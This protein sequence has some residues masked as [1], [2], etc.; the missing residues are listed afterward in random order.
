M[1]AI[2]GGCLLAVPGFAAR[3]VCPA[4]DIASLQTCIQSAA[5]VSDTT[6]TDTVV[7]TVAPGLYSG[8]QVRINRRRD[9]WIVGDTTAVESTQPRILYQDT[10]RTYTGLDPALRA[11]TSAAGT[12]GQNNGTVWIHESD[13]IRLMGLLIDGNSTTSRINTASR[14]FAYGANLGQGAPVEIRGNVGVNILLSRNVQLRYLSVTNAWNGISVLSPNLGG[15]FAFPDP[16]DPVEEVVA[17]LPTSRAGRYGNHLVERCRIHDNVF[18]VLF[19]RDWDLNSVVRNNLFWGNYLRHWGDPRT[20]AGYIRN[21]EA[22]DKAKR[23]DGSARSL[24]YTTVGGAFLMTDVALTPYRIHNNTFHNNAT[25]FSGYY[26][27]GTQ[28]LFYNNLVGKPYQFFRRALDLP[29][30]ATDGSYTAFRNGYTQTERNSEMLQY[31]SEHQRANRVVAQDSLPANGAVVPD[32]WSA[33]GGNFRLYNMRQIRRGPTQYEGWNWRGNPRSWSNAVGE[34]DSLSMTWVPDT[35]ALGTIAQQADT[36]GVVRWV[37]HNMWTGARRD[38]MDPNIGQNWSPPWLPMDIRRSLGDPAIFRNTGG[39]DLRWTLRMPFDTVSST[40]S[41]SWLTPL[42]SNLR[43]TGW[44]GYEGTSTQALPIGAYDLAGIWA[45]PSRRI[46]LRDTLIETV[47]DS[48]VRFRM[49]VSGEGISDSDIVSL[50]VHEAKFYNDVPV[51]DTVFNQ[52]PDTPGSANTTTRVNSV[53]SSKPWPLPYA[54]LSDDYNRPGYRVD[55]SL[56]RRKLAPDNVFLARIGAGKRLPADSLYARAEVVLKATLKDGSVVY[57]NPGVF[58]FSRPRFQFEVTVVDAATGIELPLDADGLSRVAQAYQPLKVVVKARTVASLPVPFKGYGNVQMGNA[59]ALHG[60]DGDDLQEGSA[61]LW[62]T[63]S[64]NDTVFAFFDQNDS[65]F[66]TLRARRSPSSGTLV[67][68]AVFVGTNDRALPYFIEGRSVPV[69]VVSGAI[70][71]ATI[72]SVLRF[73]T[74][75]LAAPDVALKVHA[76]ANLAGRRDTL[77]SDGVTSSANVS[78]GPKGESLRLVLQVRDKYGN[79]VQDSSSA[80]KALYIRLS[81]VLAPGRYPDVAPDLTWL[82]L[83]SAGTATQSLRLEWDSTGRAVAWVRMSSLPYRSVLAAL[84]A[85]IVDS[86][87]N[88]IGQ[89]GASRDSGIADTTWIRSDRVDLSLAWADTLGGTFL[90]GRPGWVGEWIP[91]RLKLRDGGRGVS[92]TGNVALSSSSP[93]SF[94]AVRGDTTRATS[95]AFLGDSLSAIVWIRASDSV[96]ST[97][98]SASALDLT[99]T[100]RDLRFRYPVAVSSSF[101]DRDCDGRIDELTVRLDGPVLFRATSGTLLGDTLD[102]VFPHQHLSPSALAAPG[103]V[104]IVTDSVIVVS[105]DPAATTAADIRADRLFLRNPLHPDRRLE[106]SL[107]GLQDQAPPVA[108]SAHLRQTGAGVRTDSLV[109]RLSETLDRSAL[110]AGAPAPF[111]ARRGSIETSL[112][113]TRLVRPVQTLDSGLYAFVFTGANGLLSRGD[114]IAIDSASLVDLAG[115]RSGRTCPNATLPLSFLPIYRVTIDTIRREDRVVLATPSVGAKVALDR[116]GLGRDTLLIA[117]TDTS[118]NVSSVRNG[119]IVRLVLQVRDEQGTPVGRNASHLTGAAILVEHV[120]APDRFP[121]ANRDTNRVVLDNGGTP[122]RSTRLSF[123]STGRAIA[124]ILVSE[125]P[126]SPVLVAIRA[127][128]V[129]SLGHEMGTPAS[130]LDS[131]LTDTTWLRTPPWTRSVHWVDTNGAPLRLSKALVGQ[132]IPVRLKIVDGPTGRIHTGDLAV[133]ALA[134]L[135]VHPRKGDTSL[136]ATLSFSNDS[137]SGVLWIRPTD[138][139][140]G[141]WIRANGDSLA[142]TAGGLDV[143]YPAATKATF[144]DRD[145]DGRIDQMRINLDGPVLFRPEQG[146]VAGDSLDARFPHQHL[147]PSAYGSPASFR[148]V[149]EST[150]VL[151]WDPTS[152]VASAG[153]SPDRIVVGNPLRPGRTVE[154]VLPVLS[155]LAPPVGLSALDRQSWSNGQLDSL[156]VRFSETIH[157]GDFPAGAS[158]PFVLVRD[159]SRIS[160]RDLRLD[161]SVALLDSGLYLFVVR[162]AAGRL[163]PGDS[164]AIDSTSVADLAGNRSA[165]T[166]PNAAFPLGIRPRYLPTRGYVIDVDGDGNADSVHLGFA[167]SL[168]ALPEE[169]LVRW[170]TPPETLLVSRAELEALGVRTSDSAFTVPTR[171]WRG[172]TVILGTDTLHNVPRT[173]G[174]WDSAWFEGGVVREPLDDRVPPVVIRA[175]MAWA[176]S[177]ADTTLLDTLLVDFSEPVQGCAEGSDP[178]RCLEARDLATGGNTPPREALFPLGSMLLRAEGSVWTILVPRTVSSIVPG[179]SLKALPGSRGGSLSDGTVARNVPGDATPLVVVRGDPAPP[180]A[181]SMLDRDGDGRVDAVVLHYRTPPRGEAFPSFEFDWCDADG[182]SVVLSSDSVVGHDSLRWIAVLDR[183]GSFP[184]TGCAS[185]APVG[186]QRS[187]TTYGFPLR[188]SAGAVLHP[189]ARLD[190]SSALEGPDTLRVRP[191]EPLTDPIQSVLLEF[192]RGGVVVSPDSVRFLSATRGN[193]GIWTVVVEGTY[194]PVPGDEVRLSTSGSVLDASSSRNRP[195]PNHPWVVLSGGLRVPYAAAYR[196]ED[197]DGR[198]ETAVFDFATP[199]LVGTRLRVADP[200][201]TNSWREYVVGPSDSGRTRVVF[202]FPD[203]AWGQDVTSLVR[204]DLGLLRPPVGFDTLLFRD[205]PFPLRDEVEPV[206][207]SATLRLTSDTAGVD[208][209]VLRVSEPILFDPTQGIARFRP[210]TDPSKDG[211]ALFLDPRYRDRIVYDSA[212]GTITLLL[213]P[214]PRDASNPV[215][216]DSMRLS[217]EGVRDTSENRPGE[218]AKWV[219]VD[220]NDRVFPPHLELTNPIIRGP[221]RSGTQI[222]GSQFEV[223][224]RPSTPQGDVAWQKLSPSGWTPG[225]SAYTP[226]L[227]GSSRSDREGAVVYLQTNVPTTLQLY[228]YDN[229]GTFV[230]QKSQ[231]ITKAM[232]EDLPRSPIG[233]VDVGILWKGQDEGGR[234]VGTGVY[235]VR[236]IALRDPRPEDGEAGRSSVMFFNKIVN[237]GV[238]VGR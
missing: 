10:L 141:A 118:R 140:T 120:L 108:L 227:P 229:L 132:W 230:G 110:V 195:H 192:R 59:G 156:E 54:F 147:T 170:G 164:L 57:S 124:E 72:D 173:T 139:V 135:G 66:D 123:D 109:V 52:G 205:A 5:E 106:L 138:S 33:A 23:A 160:L 197:K 223:V 4:T 237:V 224:A 20:P 24:A 84:R 165:T 86:A 167:D 62:S 215:D 112:A 34:Q 3:T 96:A 163:L 181:G 200:A 146:L 107:V 119:G 42:T 61:G 232:L 105:W 45:A 71:Q 99:D 157:T 13:N 73:D 218:V 70:Y 95:V 11:D 188:D 154:I 115:N 190:P 234:L 142:D 41:S 16:N 228:I 220:A 94:H 80:R 178:A 236:L 169:I 30:E 22:I 187:R 186:R 18:G 97:S 133:S 64:P 202:S 161:R 93:V 50:V 225:T 211:H 152:I 231:R 233:L 28:H 6:R 78:A 83:D 148:I 155:D 235:L 15:A 151:E 117:N 76:N 21:L 212:A 136:V 134:P 199:P 65:V 204:P 166:C 183:P 19:Q 100:L 49:N 214:F 63:R 174:P 191:S 17:T 7:V 91:M 81:Q 60:P 67:Y 131:A 14:I 221:G 48:M 55:D 75:S 175:R 92:W 143:R 56:T 111:V 122:S 98:L 198:I 203:S 150:I 2:L 217:W 29:V 44:P 194:R 182:Q 193:D 74:L 88:E 37:R 32:Y 129:D 27:T 102:A 213:K 125:L 159:G 206:L 137:L 101:H 127:A 31:M 69:K 47:T 172:Q 168:G 51:S 210:S 144:H 226:S 79:P 26:K 177:S 121:D 12:Y 40:T 128:L 9:L 189:W 196:D 238:H 149:A 216:G 145:C 158:F 36:G 208:T 38:A 116:L 90:A 43:L 219:E 53:L 77:L 104:R 184:A 126:T 130:P 89:A 8:A 103:E 162:G 46:V 35:A 1:V 179:D 87:N 201:G 68:R 39:F 171:G 207:R 180:S 113:A 153:R 222:P 185:I 85:A 58:M 209:L 25:I 114:S 176:G 82:A